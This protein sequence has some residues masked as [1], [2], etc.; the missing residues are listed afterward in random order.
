MPTAA[1]APRLPG[2]HFETVRPPAVPSLPPMDVAAVA[3]VARSGPVGE[4]VAVQDVVRFEEVFGGDLAL[5]WDPERGERAYAH[6]PQ[7]V[8]EFFRNGGRR[9]WVLR[10][11]R[12]P[13]VA[14]FRLPGLLR[15]RSGEVVGAGWMVA[16]S[17]G[18]WADGVRIGASALRTGVPAEAVALRPEESGLRLADRESR[19]LLRLELD[20]GEVGFFPPGRATARVRKASAAWEDQS[21]L[22]RAEKA[23]KPGSHCLE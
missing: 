3:G 11:A 23:A 17:P 14:R 13:E 9:C 16:S 4:P 15:A 1:G 12:D 18:S 10:L 8:R 7:A 22:G 2:I 20:D 6:L 21:C 5:A 19:D